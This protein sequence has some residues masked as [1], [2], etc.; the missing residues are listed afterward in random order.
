MS[1]HALADA[2]RVL[3]DQNCHHA[4]SFETSALTRSAASAMLA[5]ARKSIP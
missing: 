5:P 3:S 4:T 2:A 1:G